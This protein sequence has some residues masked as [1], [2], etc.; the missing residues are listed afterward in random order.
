M[1]QGSTH[2]SLAGFGKGSRYKGLNNEN[3]VLVYS[4]AELS[5]LE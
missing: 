5:P 1:E 2:G 4:M 3:R